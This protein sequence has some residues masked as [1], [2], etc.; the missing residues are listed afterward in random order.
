VL[1]FAT[2]FG[3]FAMVQVLVGANF[4][5]LPLWQADAMFQTNGRFNDLAATTILGFAILVVLATVLVIRGRD[6]ATAAVPGGGIPVGT[7]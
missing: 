2:S 1:V 5:T 3:D 6:G 4:E 7:R